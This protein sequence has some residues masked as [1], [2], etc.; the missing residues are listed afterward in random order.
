MITE[1][2]TGEETLPNPIRLLSFS[3]H[4]TIWSDECNTRYA[5]VRK[6]PIR[7]YRIWPMTR[8]FIIRQRKKT[9]LRHFRAQ[10]LTRETTWRFR[11]QINKGK[12]HRDKILTMVRFHD[13]SHAL[14]QVSN[15][16][17][18]AK[19]FHSHRWICQNSD[20]WR[21]NLMGCS[22]QEHRRWTRRRINRLHRR[23]WVIHCS[24]TR[25]D[26]RKLRRVGE[27]LA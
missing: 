15:C 8:F 11:R 4:C 22:S 1:G 23:R 24:F 10:A 14:N 19:H 26:W 17:A 6:N 20:P 7:P 5:S 25:E 3:L 12:T 27:K 21:D 16:D 18:W 2:R 9:G 13:R